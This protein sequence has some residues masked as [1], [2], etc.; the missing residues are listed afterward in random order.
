M[1]GSPQ[2]IQRF[3]GKGA[4]DKGNRKF[5]PVEGKVAI[6]VYVGIAADHLDSLEPRTVSAAPR[7]AFRT[8]SLKEVG[9][10]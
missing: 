4:P 2:A 5:T 9:V 6:L 7:T 8:A 10:S 3:R 1:C